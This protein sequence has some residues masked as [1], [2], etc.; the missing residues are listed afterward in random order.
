MAFDFQTFYQDIILSKIV[1]SAII[2]F[3]GITVGK[4]LGKLTQRI[5][6]EL[7]V[8][9][10]ARK[11]PFSRFNFEKR[12]AW[13]VSNLIYLITIITI[14]NRLE[15]TQFLWKGILLFLVLIIVFALLL[16]LKDLFPNII[17]FAIIKKRKLLKKGK[18]V[19]TPLVEGKVVRISLFSVKLLTKKGDE[20]YI[21]NSAILKNFA[22]RK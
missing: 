22:T 20:I 15:I 9:K 13:L 4:I 21:P 16:D 8:N 19:K 17:S 14:L 3:V 11:L 2:F 1:T 12:I 6:S 18:N 7:E 10:I 5:L